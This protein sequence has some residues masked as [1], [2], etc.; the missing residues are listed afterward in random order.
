[1]KKLINSIALI[2][3][4]SLCLSC[5]SGDDSSKDNCSAETID[6]LRIVDTSA[7]RLFDDKERLDL[8]VKYEPPQQNLS[9]PSSF[10][11]AKSESD[12]DVVICKKVLE[13]NINRI[14][15]M[16]RGTCEI[17][18]PDYPDCEKRVTYYAEGKDPKTGK[19]VE[20]IN[21]VTEG[22]PLYILEKHVKANL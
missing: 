6:E 3:L 14:K 7:G 17:E 12:G 13:A 9:K 19:P 4:L 21:P 22:R 20:V 10:G 16:I 18:F 15:E 5:S 2:A 11:I 8:I 1:M